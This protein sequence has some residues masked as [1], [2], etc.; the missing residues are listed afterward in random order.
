MPSHRDGGYHRPRQ[1]EGFHPANDTQGVPKAIYLMT[2]GGEVVHVES[3]ARGA[4]EFLAERG[5]GWACLAS[6]DGETR[7]V[8]RNQVTYADKEV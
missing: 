2:Y 7:E 6:I 5:L 4:I 3:H 8:C 1:T